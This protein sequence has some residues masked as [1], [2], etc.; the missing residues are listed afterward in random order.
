MDH[1]PGVVARGC[2]PS[3]L[4]TIQ[5]QEVFLSRPRVTPE[6]LAL[7]KRSWEAWCS[8]SPEPLAAVV[9]SGATSLP[10]LAGALRRLLEEL[11][12]PGSGLSRTEHTILTSLADE[13]RTFGEIFRAL[14]DQEERPW[15]TDTMLV[16]VLRQLARGPVPL[17]HPLRAWG[18]TMTV[19][20]T[21]AGALAVSGAGDAVLLNGIDRWVGGTHLTPGACWRW[22]RVASRLIR[23]SAG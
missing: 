5:L 18:H 19:E 15:H 13:P 22:D 12:A 16:D 6:Q 9:E 3:Y 10:Y 4:N 7:G 20:R 8:P 11:P 14:G 23:P 2:T 21:D 17:I 1:Y